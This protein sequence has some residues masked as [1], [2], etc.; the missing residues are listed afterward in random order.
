MPKYLV[1]AD[2]SLGARNDV[3]CLS[4]EHKLGIHASPTCVIAFGEKDGALAYRVGEAGRGLEYM[5]IMMNARAS[6]SAARAMRW[7]SAHSSRPPSGRARAC[8]ASRRWRSRTGPAPIIEHPDVKRM[9]LLMKSQ[10]EASRALA[11]YAAFQLDLAQR[12]HR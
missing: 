11:L 10:T 3:R 2:G 4:I 1:N 6:R 8:R 7:A 12:R 9:L 5:F